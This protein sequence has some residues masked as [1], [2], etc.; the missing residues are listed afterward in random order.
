MIMKIK[1]KKYSSVKIFIQ[2]DYSDPLGTK[3]YDLEHTV[4]EI[5]QKGVQQ[6]VLRHDSYVLGAFLQVLEGFPRLLNDGS[7]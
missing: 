4:D 7:F 3:A 5:F 6:A 2:M 1:F